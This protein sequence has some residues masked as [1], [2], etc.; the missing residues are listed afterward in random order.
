M[1]DRRAARALSIAPHS[2]PLADLEAPWRALLDAAHPG[3]PFRSYPWLSSWWSLA[4]PKGEAH[5]LVARNDS[6]VVGILPLY[7]APASFGGRRLRFFGDGIVGSDYLGVIARPAD[8]DRCARAF[9]THL[10]SRGA[11]LE[12]DDLDAGDPLVAAVA[13]AEGAAIAPRYLCPF[14]TTRGD[15]DDYLEALPD[16][17]GA[18]WHRRRKWLEKRAGHRIEVLATPDEIARGLDALFELHRRRW[19]LE[20]GSDAID[21]PTV[22]AFHRAAGR[23]MA[24]AGWARIYLLHVEGAPRAALYGFRHADRFAFYQA[25]HDPEWRPRSVGTV[26]LGE[27]IRRCFAEQLAEFDF[28][29]GSEPYKLRWATGHRETVRLQQRGAGLGPWLD[30]EGRAL[31]WR[32]RHGLKRAFPTSALDW[33]RASRKRLRGAR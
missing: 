22:E 12:L 21:G 3:A 16:G 24:E 6:E 1:L 11:E 32:A 33:L 28:L 23:G 14:V 10:L 25:G 9:A 26:L 30:H 8:A 29:R 2:G 17:I 4:S 13:E 18:Q 20:G 31:Y 19:A 5:I 7:A 15:F 27:V